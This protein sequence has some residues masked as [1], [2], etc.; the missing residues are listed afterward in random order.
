[1]LFQAITIYQ[2]Y[3]RRKSKTKL[4]YSKRYCVE[5][6]Q[7]RRSQ[8]V[9]CRNHLFK[10]WAQKIH[11]EH[12]FKHKHKHCA[13]LSNKISKLKV[14]KKKKITTRSH[15]LDFGTTL[16]R[17]V[18]YMRSYVW[19]DIS[20]FRLPSW[21]RRRPLLKVPNKLPTRGQKDERSLVLGMNPSIA[22]FLV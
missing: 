16:G 18:L 21:G 11:P 5:W 6:K 15:V 4:N 19:K 8:L 17:N 1:M 10:I 3:V 2:W 20:R 22:T 13:N 12:C 14:I 9:T 7:P